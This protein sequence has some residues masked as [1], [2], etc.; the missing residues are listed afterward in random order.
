M[1]YGVKGSSLIIANPLNPDH[2]C[3]S[4]PQSVVEA[5]WDGQLWQVELISKQE[6]FNLSWFTPAVWKYPRTC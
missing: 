2:T 1:A 5:S 4:L 3:E 6:K